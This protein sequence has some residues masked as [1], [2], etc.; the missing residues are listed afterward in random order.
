MRGGGGTM[1][2]NICEHDASVCVCV[3]V[4]VCRS[5]EEQIDLNFA[6]TLAHAWYQTLNE[7]HTHTQAHL[8]AQTQTPKRTNAHAC[9]HGALARASIASSPHIARIFIHIYTD[10]LM[11]WGVSPRQPPPPP[12][13]PAAA[14]ATTTTT[15]TTTTHRPTRD[16]VHATRD[17]AQQTKLHI[18]IYITFAVSLSNEQVQ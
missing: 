12:L 2:T 11:G 13:T 3:R 9:W 4:F 8:R 7:A 6:L 10:T 16:N 15:T 14:A 18:I 17:T 1:R 5:H